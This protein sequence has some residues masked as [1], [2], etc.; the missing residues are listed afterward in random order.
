[1]GMRVI[2]N[3]DVGDLSRAAEQA[4]WAESM[5]YDGV[6]SNETAHDP[7]FRCSWPLVPLLGSA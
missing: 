5:G 7:F 1:M 6:T 4:R 3:L 2:Y